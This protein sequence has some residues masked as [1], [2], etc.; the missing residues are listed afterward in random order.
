MASLAWKTTFLFLC[1]D[2]A[3]KTSGFSLDWSCEKSR[4]NRIRSN[5]FQV[6]AKQE[7]IKRLNFVKIQCLQ[8]D[9][10]SALELSGA[11][12][13]SNASTL[14]TLFTA[15]TVPFPKNE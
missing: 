9:I 12:S 4:P 1:P 10:P 5:S 2:G 6:G 7:T 14:F 13:S 15:I 11:T 8:S 3:I